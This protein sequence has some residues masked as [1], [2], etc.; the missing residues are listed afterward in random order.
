MRSLSIS[1]VSSSVVN[2]ENAGEEE[3][4]DGGSLNTT[5]SEKERRTLRGS[6]ICSSWASYRL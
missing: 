3:D 4:G 2:L 1:I 5:D 6:C